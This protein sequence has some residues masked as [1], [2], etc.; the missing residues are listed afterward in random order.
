MIDEI[1]KQAES[2]LMELLESANLKEKDILVVG[3]ST[4]EVTGHKIG[5][6]SVLDVAKELVEGIYP[7][8]KERGIY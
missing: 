2:A 6:Y 1:K 7:I 5:T 8:L 3:C 4:S